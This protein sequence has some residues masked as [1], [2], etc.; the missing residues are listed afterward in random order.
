MILLSFN[1]LVWFNGKAFDFHSNNMGS[2]PI[3]SSTH[4]GKIMK[5]STRK[6]VK[7]VFNMLLVVI[8]GVFL[9]P[10]IT[11]TPFVLLSV[12]CAS[13]SFRCV[14]AIKD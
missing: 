13:L 3:I 8:G 9:L 7:T 10:V 6:F 5:E 14:K 4:I 2:T 12:Y 1:K 11:I